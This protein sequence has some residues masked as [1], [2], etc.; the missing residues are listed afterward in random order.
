MVLDNV[1]EIIS[2][3][4]NFKRISKVRIY[5]TA[6]SKMKNWKVSN[7]ALSHFSKGFFSVIGLDVKTNYGH[8]ERWQQPIIKQNEIGILG[9]ISKVINNKRFF[10]VQCKIEPGNINFV[11]LSPT[12]QA[13][14]SNYTQKHGGQKPHFLDFF[15][16]PQKKVIVDQIQSEQGARFYK[17]RNRNI[18]IE[19][20]TELELKNNFFGLH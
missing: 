3:S 15:L 11:Q 12:L 4:N 8:I 9:F 2:F 14:K 7:S 18:V 19:V 17:K 20:N 5:K 10:L 1:N 6:F 16:D 13:T